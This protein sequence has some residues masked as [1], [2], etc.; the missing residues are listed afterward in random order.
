VAVLVTLNDK[1]MESV[2]QNRETLREHG[3]PTEEGP[4]EFDL[5]E[6]DRGEGLGI[7]EERL[8]R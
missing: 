4:P 7:P 5:G 8:R 1:A 3:G 2:M 6:V